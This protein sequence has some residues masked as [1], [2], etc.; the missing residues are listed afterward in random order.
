VLDREKLCLFP[1]PQ[2]FDAS[3]IDYAYVSLPKQSL[4]EL[5][6]ERTCPPAILFRAG[7]LLSTLHTEKRGA[8]TL[9]HSDY[10]PHN[11]FWDGKTLFVIDAHPPEYLGFREDLLW[12][13]TRRDL[14]AFVTCIFSNVGARA[15]LHH[16]DYYIDMAHHFLMGY[17]KHATVPSHFVGAITRH[18]QDVFTMKRRA[19]IGRIHAM[20]HG[21]FY[22]AVAWWMINKK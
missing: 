11:L 20:A 18:V 7:E 9:L 6:K 17:K 15:V 12:G 10:V 16:R 14:V 4:S 13:D 2:T 22:G 5:L 8:K 1:R 21:L 19:G 3:G